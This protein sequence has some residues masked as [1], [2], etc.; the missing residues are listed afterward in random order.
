MNK[1]FLIK[2]V[3]DV[4]IPRLFLIMDSLN[5]D[6]YN[7][8]RKIGHMGGYASVSYDTQ[9]EPVCICRVTKSYELTHSHFDC[10][11]NL[12]DFVKDVVARMQL[13]VLI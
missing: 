9:D 2:N 1:S 10:Y 13:G 12:D 3:K 11:E 8:F 7:E 6:V 5:I 4:D